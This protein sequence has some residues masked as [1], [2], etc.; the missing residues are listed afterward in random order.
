MNNIRTNK[1]RQ[2]FTLPEDVFR[3]FAAI[4]P[5]GKRS[6]IVAML[7]EREARRRE[8]ALARACDAA[9]SDAGLTALEEDFQSLEDTTSEPWDPHGR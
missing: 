8:Q 7:I 5:E 4:V 9:N 3:R 2:T 6:A 1:I